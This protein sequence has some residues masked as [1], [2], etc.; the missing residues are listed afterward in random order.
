[1][2]ER[3]RVVGG[4]AVAGAEARAA[5]SGWTRE[6]WTAIQAVAIGNILMQ[7]AITPVAA[8]LPTIARDYGVGL[9]VAGW[10]ASG[11][12]LTLTGFMLIAGRL[13][14]L[15]GHRRVFLAGIAVSTVSGTL[16]GVAPDV[17]T[18]V[19]L[20]AV[21]GIG[22]ALMLGNG[23]A[24]LT[25]A[26]ADNQRGRAIGIVG[27]AAAFGSLVGTMLSTL[28]LN[29]L[30]WHWL[31]V[32][33]LPLGLVGALSA[34][35]LSDANATR[36]RPGAGGR[37]RPVAWR[38]IDW[39][40]SILLLAGVTALSLSLSHL[41]EGP[42]T[43][44]AGWGWHLSMHTLAAALIGAFVLVER[45]VP[46]PIIQLGQ[47][48]NRLF[49]F[50]LIGHG[51]LHLTMMAQFFLLPFMI[52]RGLGLS[53]TASGNFIVVTQFTNTLTSFAGG[54][55][56]DRTRSKWIVVFGMLTIAASMVLQGLF[57]GVGYAVLIL[58]ACAASFGMGFFQTAN[59]VLVMSVVEPDQRGF[60]SGM[61]ETVR[62]LGHGLGIALSSAVMAL[63]TGGVLTAAAQSAAYVEGFQRACLLVSALTLA[64]A[65]L[66]WLAIR[67]TGQR[68][69]DDDREPPA[70]WA[71][72]TEDIPEPRG[73]LVG[74]R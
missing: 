4:T 19:G 23:L 21:Q 30:T 33:N 16:L 20:R 32:V 12:L 62:Q 69:P 54:W 43:F 41:H 73:T 9:S 72:A 61:L 66:S 24:I 67:G 47:F 7:I 53:A 50:F 22:G 25:D 40:G 31:F 17:W 74:A 29:Y 5:G 42:E 45:R 60:A 10:I 36:H 14:D 46:E 57:G 59:N 18:M 56:Y 39:A 3:G 71:G 48:K 64:A 38:R 35:G 13:G 6:R 2:R 65:L 49:T 34:L 55:L 1:M 44:E 26:F 15:F 70:E 11:Y 63:S 28:A 58:I 52:E 27:M 51:V 37:S 8:M 68:P